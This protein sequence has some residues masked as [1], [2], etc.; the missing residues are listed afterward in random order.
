MKQNK[1][2]EMNFKKRLE[3]FLINHCVKTG[4]STHLG[5]RFRVALTHIVRV[6]HVS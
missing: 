2:L 5:H 1:T 6:H 3:T 4:D